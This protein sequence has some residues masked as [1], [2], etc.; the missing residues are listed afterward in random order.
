LWST[1]ILHCTKFHNYLIIFTEMLLSGK[2]SFAAAE[3][4]RFYDGYL[5]RLVGCGSTHFDNSLNSLL[6]SLFQKMYCIIGFELWFA[7]FF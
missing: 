7:F 2:V 4:S 1:Q 6:A 3:Y 5:S